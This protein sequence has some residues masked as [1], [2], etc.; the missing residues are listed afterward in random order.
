MIWT[1][2]D[3]WGCWESKNQIRELVWCLKNQNSIIHWKQSVPTLLTNTNISL[4]TCHN[5]PLGPKPFF[6][7]FWL[8]VRTLQVRMMNGDTLTTKV[9]DAKVIFWWNF[10][11]FFVFIPASSNRRIHH[12]RGDI[13][14]ISTSR[15]HPFSI[16]VIVAHSLW[17]YQLLLTI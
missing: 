6:Y 4:G 13:L 1:K 16:T 17:D 12:P 5:A 11:R 10:T 7:I 9:L 14:P 15:F 2:W 8:R 3:F